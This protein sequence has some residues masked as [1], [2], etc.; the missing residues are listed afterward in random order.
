MLTLSTPLYFG[1]CTKYP[2]L[3][4]HLSF[5][6]FLA[7]SSLGGMDKTLQ[8]G[9][10]FRF[11]YEGIIDAG[12]EAIKDLAERTRAWKFEA[13]IDAAQ[14]ADLINLRGEIS[15]DYFEMQINSHKENWAEGQ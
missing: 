5:I 6:A 3:N 2:S 10:T 13:V 7:E 11:D 8:F 12:Q 14:H 1:P 9:T 4:D 15:S